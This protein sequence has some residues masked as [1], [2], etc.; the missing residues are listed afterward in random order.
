V[1]LAGVGWLVFVLGVGTRADTAREAAIR[2]VTA[3]RLDAGG[4]AV[5]N[6]APVG[7]WEAEH[8]FAFHW[9]ARAV[10]CDAPAAW[11]FDGKTPTFVAP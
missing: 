10:P 9:N 11:R 6:C 2:A 8:L 5:A 4:A 3:S 1:A 7:D